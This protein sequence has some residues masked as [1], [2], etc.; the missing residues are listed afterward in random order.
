MPRLLAIDTAT[1][2]CSAALLDE[3][4]ETVL[5]SRYEDM[6][7]GHAEAL[8]PMVQV[9]MAES[10]LPMS[11]ISRVAVTVGPG[12]FTGCRIG[13]AFARS[14]GAALDCPVLGVSTLQAIAA[15][16]FLAERAPSQG[17]MAAVMDARRGEVYLQ[18]FASGGAPCSEA[19]VTSVEDALTV[20][21]GSQFELAGTGADILLAAA[22]AGRDSWTRAEVPDF[23]DARF[24]A[25]LA[26]RLPDPDKMPEP[27]YLR[28][29]DAK[30]PRNKP[31]LRVG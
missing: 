1:G 11:A 21:H 29:P 31:Q 7:R 14:L 18:T 12:T 15:N 2:A 26:T 6:P 17:N 3:K 22:P 23:P 27:L 19:Q 20:L 24:V 9:V 13:L 30:L 8:A 16:I 25:K 28:A 5:A 10:G 4:S